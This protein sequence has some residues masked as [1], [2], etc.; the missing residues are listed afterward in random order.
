MA[1][2]PFTG[3]RL[4]SGFFDVNGDGKVDAADTINGVPI[5]GIGFRDSAPNNPIFIGDVM[6]VSL[7]N[8]TKSSVK[9]YSATMS[10]SRVAWRELVGN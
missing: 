2:D 10:V 6:Q 5:S 4:S 9:T 1:I 7:D 3:G 8:A